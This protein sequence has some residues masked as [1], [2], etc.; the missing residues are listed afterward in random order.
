MC[1][2]FAGLAGRQKPFAGQLSAMTEP[3]SAAAKRAAL[4]S[5]ALAITFGPS[6]ALPSKNYV[7]QKSKMVLDRCFLQ[8]LQGIA[9]IC[10]FRNNDLSQRS[11]VLNLY[12]CQ[13]ISIKFPSV[14]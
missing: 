11:F 5:A 3:R 2:R 6:E 13:N 9:N 10:H 1:A 8:F 14:S 12:I 7:K 4:A